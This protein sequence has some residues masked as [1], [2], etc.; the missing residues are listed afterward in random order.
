MVTSHWIEQQDF[1]DNM[2]NGITLSFRAGFDSLEK[3]SQRLTRNA[4]P[5]SCM[6]A[7]G[8]R[9]IVSNLRISFT[10]LARIRFSILIP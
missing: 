6:I 8:A 2:E 9:V 4:I 5:A 7:D 3:I 1:N 10:T